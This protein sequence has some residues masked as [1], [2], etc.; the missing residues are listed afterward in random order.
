M[1]AS[2][3]NIGEGQRDDRVNWPFAV[4]KRQ[5]APDMR[6]GTPRRGCVTKW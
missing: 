4:T 3:V 6:E 1:P 2:W 5:V